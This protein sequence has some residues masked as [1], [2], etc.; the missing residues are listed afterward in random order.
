MAWVSAL[1]DMKAT[2]EENK[3][4]IKNTYYGVT[5]EVRK[6]INFGTLTL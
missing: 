3:A 2:G 6:E 5:N 1:P 4:D